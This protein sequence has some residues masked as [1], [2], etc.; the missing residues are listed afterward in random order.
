MKDYVIIANGPFLDKK[1]IQEAIQN[2]YIVALDGAANKLTALGIAPHAILGDFDSINTKSQQYWGIRQTFA[3]ITIE[4]KPYIGHHGVHIIPTKDQQATDLEK[5]IR[6][7]D[8]HDARSITII[9]ATGG[10]EDHHEGTKMTL[11]AT[12]KAHRP[13]VVHGEQQTLRYAKDESIELVGKPG[14]YCGFIAHHSGVGTSVGLEY[15]CNQLDFSICNRLK[16]SSAVLHIQGEALIIM[17]PQLASQ[18]DPSLNIADSMSQSTPK[19]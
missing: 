13:L 18:R 17:P 15:E 8:Q 14:D 12:Y 19:P 16:S 6:Y 5:A 3:D 7:C 2:K 4:S 9:C 10:R 1:I 11:K